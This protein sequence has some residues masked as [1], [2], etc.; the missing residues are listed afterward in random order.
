M[1]TLKPSF[2]FFFFFLFSFMAG[3]IR[4]QNT[5][6]TI[7]V[8]VG[9]ILDFDDWVGRMWLSCINMS[10]VD[11]YA[12]HGHY[13]TR[14]F[15]HARDSKNDVIGAAA[16]ATDL[17]TNVGAL[18]IIG[19]TTSR[20][21]N[22]V[23][24]L[25]EKAQVPIISFTASVPSL[26][27]IKR[28]YFFRSTET[29][30]TQVK[31]IAAI[32]QNFGWREAV[33]IYVDDDYGVGI[34]PYLV[35]SLQAVDTN[36]PH[37]SAISPWAS[38]AD[39]LEELYKLK[40]MQTRVFIVHMLPSLGTRLFTKAKE[41]GMMDIGY[42]WIM[43]DGMTNLLN[44]LNDSDIDS[45][46]GVLGVRPYIP[47]TKELKDFRLRWKRKLHRDHP[48]MVDADL[49]IYGWLAYDATMALAMAVEQVAGTTT[50]LG[51]KEANVSSNLVRL[52][53]VG[54]S[55]NG[56][57]LSQALS[58]ISFRGLTG[59]FRF[60]NQ[61]L[62]S[63]AIQI[64]NINGVVEAKGIGFWTPTKGIFKRWKFNSTTSASST[65]QSKLATIMWPGEPTSVPKGWEIPTNGT[66]LR[67]GVPVKDGFT[68]FVKVTR[69]PKTNAT[70]VTGYCIDVFNAVMDRLPYDVSYDY[71]PFV[72]SE[73]ES[74][75]T[76][77]DLIY[78]V[79]LGKFDAVVG[80]VTILANRSNYVDF[81][82]P[83]S[84]SGISMVVP[85]KDT[86]NDNALIF[87][88]PFKLDLWVTTLC[89]FVIIGFVVWVLEHRINKD[90]RGPPSQQAGTS[91]WFAFST[92]VFSQREKVIN[93]LAR[94]VVIIWS[95]VV[96]IITQSYTASLSSLLTVQQ[97]QPAITDIT[98]LIRNREVVGYHKDSF[99]K[100]ILRGLG[101]QDFQL[102]SYTS[103]QECDE[104]LSKGSQNGGV[105]AVFDQFP[106]V[107]LIL[108]RNCSNYTSIEAR[109]FMSR[110]PNQK[111]ISSNIQQFKTGGF[112][113]AFP[114]GSP[115]VPDVS[116]AILKVTE[117][118]DD[119]M[120]RIEDEWLSAKSIC[121]AHTN[122]F[123]SS[124]LGVSSFWVLFAITGGTSLLALT[125]YITMFVHQHWEDL[126]PYDSMW[127]RIV[128]LFRIFN[129]KDSKW[130]TFRKSEAN[131]GDNLSDHS[132]GER[133]AASSALHEGSVENVDLNPTEQAN[134]DVAT[135]NIDI[136]PTNPNQVMPTSTG[137]YHGT[138]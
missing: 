88:K 47:K 135:F 7:P 13:K 66:K 119:M 50:N 108:A 96:L 85:V 80:D 115:L 79:Y 11:F 67:I 97:L 64:V 74:A 4:A 25:G 136:E 6:S 131:N 92:I 3:T 51:I 116:R 76:Y 27:S 114:L 9:V 17:I 1:M 109:T 83:Y 32:V 138:N 55:K 93:N 128:N 23:I 122:S 2:S 86:K 78:Q 68:E 103:P 113:F 82:M 60:V 14:L 48:N 28:P 37:Q 5:G 84:E 57:K 95:L 21:A 104:L 38:D 89:S 12:A 101:F 33:P 44:L 15:L 16:A 42:V 34:L 127:G 29:D 35:A 133:Q 31:A 124:S 54:V 62:Q 49:D 43:T 90:F 41:A 52:E 126:R 24:E 120:G 58:S 81:A 94:I 112:G 125:T 134:K 137:I 110:F 121:A 10:L 59:D 105:A 56:H 71:V 117:D 87:L 30:K 123:S 98:E 130:H 99:V 70:K 22:F 53:T 100:D 45:M 75:G 69:N 8:N 91:L 106:A 102:L 39:I 118:E 36:V 46:Q 18:A 77:N 72:N 19:P 107:K 73:G 111:N 40:T 61:Q 63:S 20:Q 132:Y 26:T 65:S 129:Q